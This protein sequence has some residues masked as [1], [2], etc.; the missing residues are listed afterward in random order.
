[1]ERK[2]ES[3]VFVGIL[4]LKIKFLWANTPF[5]EISLRLAARSLYSYIDVKE[6]VA[7]FKLDNFPWIFYGQNKFFHWLVSVKLSQATGF[8]SGTL[9][10]TS[11]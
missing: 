6:Q 2:E 11:L 7:V 8:L 5:S 9:T 1:M 4:Q 10:L 3:I